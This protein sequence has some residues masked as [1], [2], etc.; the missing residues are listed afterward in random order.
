MEFG[1]NWTIHGRESI[2][3]VSLIHG[4]NKPPRTSNGTCPSPAPARPVR[5]HHQAGPRKPLPLPA[6]VA[7]H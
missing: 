5:L 2:P 1:H 3:G 6:E 4:T 7:L